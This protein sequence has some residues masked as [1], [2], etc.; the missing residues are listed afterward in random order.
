MVRKLT[1]I[2]LLLVIVK[3]IS[4]QKKEKSPPSFDMDLI[5]SVLENGDIIC[6]RGNRYWSDII[7]D[8]SVNDKR[9][10]HV[11][12]IRIVDGVVAVIH[13][14]GSSNHKYSHVKEQTLEIFLENAT[15]VGIYRSDYAK[16]DQVTDIAVRYIGV[17]FDWDFDLY[18][19]TKIYC[20]ELIYIILNQIESSIKLKIIHDDKHGKDFIPIEAFSDSN[21]FYEVLFLG[22]SSH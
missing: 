13:S 22:I 2:L 17:P 7:A 15:S 3:V 11:G 6:R 20:T 16:G 12:I 9:F 8:F 19:H 1:Y 4:V 5:Y 14:E 21:Y 10:S 18:D